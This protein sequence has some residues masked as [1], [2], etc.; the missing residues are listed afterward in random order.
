VRA[1]EKGGGAVLSAE[2]S[3]GYLRNTAGVYARPCVVV[4][5]RGRDR[6]DFVSFLLGKRTEFAQ[7]GTAVE[8]V[9]LDTGGDVVGMA[10]AVVDEDETVVLVEMDS[11]PVE[12]VHGVAES[13]GLDEVEVVPQDSSV[14]AC[15]GPLSWAVAALAISEP[16][17]DVLL[18]EWREGE[19]AGTPCRLVRLGTTAEY[20]YLVVVPGDAR[21][22]VV[23]ALCEAAAGHGGGPVSDDALERARVEVNY[24]VLPGQAAGLSAFEAGLQWYVT[25]DRDDDYVGKDALVF[26]KP[27][28]RVVAA[29]A[30]G[31]D[32]P[33]AGGVVR[34]GDLDVGRVQVSSPRSG[35]PD[36]LGL[37]VLDDPY[38]APD[39]VLTVDGVSV[40]TVSRPVVE[41]KSW[42]RR[43]GEFT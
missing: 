15:E 32:M 8:S 6:A 36:G 30:K 27:A 42:V 29:I 5:V 7:P 13:L 21:D 25:L 31:A 1:R 28:R 16:I 33:G 37:L 43:I 10:I 34:D 19:I 18:N 26:D 14:V 3:Y 11:A 23:E 22:A 40:R 4:A 17:G 41:P 12:H 24:P 2:K 9:I 38:S 39:S 20:G 35:Q